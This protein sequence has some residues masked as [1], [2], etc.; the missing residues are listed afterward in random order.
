[1]RAL[2]GEASSTLNGFS[3]SWGDYDGDGDLDLHVANNAQIDSLY[4]NDAGVMTPVAVTTMTTGTS[5]SYG[6]AW[7]DYDGDGDLDLSVAINGYN[8]VAQ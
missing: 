3:A 5:N 7:G 6:G 4:R 1:M 2:T 8:L